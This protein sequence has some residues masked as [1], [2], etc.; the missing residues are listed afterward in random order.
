MK[1]MNNVQP[2]EKWIKIYKKSFWDVG[3]KNKIISAE[4]GQTFDED[5]GG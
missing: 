4:V 5:D 2:K 1:L 3:N